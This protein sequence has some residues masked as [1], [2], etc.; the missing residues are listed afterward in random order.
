MLGFATRGFLFIFSAIL[1]TAHSGICPVTS[2]LL[3][4]WDRKDTVTRRIFKPSQFQ[5]V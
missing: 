5:H 2:L 3:C 4:I 1:E